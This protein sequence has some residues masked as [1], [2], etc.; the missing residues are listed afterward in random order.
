MTGAN[1]QDWVP[2]GLIWDKS[3]YK[4]NIKD[5]WLYM[6]VAEVMVMMIW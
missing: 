3:K 2:R 4:D 1:G 5:M 6:V